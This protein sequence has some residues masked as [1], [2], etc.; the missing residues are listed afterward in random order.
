MDVISGLLNSGIL[1][2]LRSHPANKY[3]FFRSYAVHG[4]CLRLNACRSNRLRTQYVINV[5]TGQVP[6]YTVEPN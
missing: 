2:A 6:S 5:V 4:C 3:R 1:E